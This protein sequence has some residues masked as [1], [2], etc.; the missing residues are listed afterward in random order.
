MKTQKIKNDIFHMFILAVCM[1]V[2]LTY[3]HPVSA[4]TG[5]EDCDEQCRRDLARA[6]A[7][8]AQYHTIDVALEEG[9]VP[10]SP[11]VE[12]PGVGA[13]GIHYAHFGRAGNPNLDPAEPE[14]L[15][16]LPEKNGKLR[17]VG[18]EYV[19]FGPP[20]PPVPTLFGQ[21]FEYNPQLGAYTLHVWVWRNNPNGMF[22]PFNSKLSCP[23][24]N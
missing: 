6:K 5:N 15:L 9:F 7:A 8:T 21:E 1:G 4:Q 12:I 22:A 24:V 20:I 17:L 16:Y 2:F 23:T 18:L 14:V 11:C 19:R 10:T 13:M 3:A